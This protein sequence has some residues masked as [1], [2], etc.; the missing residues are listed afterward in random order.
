M[1]VDSHCHLDFPEFAPELDAVVARAKDAGVGVCVTIGTKMSGFA[2][3]REVA[4]RFDNVWCSVGI[5]PHEA[6]GELLDSATPLIEA[7]RHRK[8]SVSARADSTITTNTR[9]AKHSRRISGRIS[10]PRAKPACR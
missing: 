1:L 4:D 5:H 8:V 3:V 9:R 2:R 6:E 7:A 10:L